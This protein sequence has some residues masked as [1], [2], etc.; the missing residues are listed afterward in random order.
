MRGSSP[1]C[2]WVWPSWVPVRRPTEIVVSITIVP[3]ARG[4]ATSPA[5]RARLASTTPISAPETK[6]VMASPNDRR[7]LPDYYFVLG[8]PPDATETELHAAWPRQPSGRA[9]AREVDQLG[10]RRTD[11]RHQAR[12]IRPTAGS[13]WLAPLR[14]GPVISPPGPMDDRKPRGP[15]ARAEGIRPARFRRTLGGDDEP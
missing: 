6:E 10:A 12:G 5:R 9:R 11:Q 1:D 14:V 3:L 4:L 15:A 2:C 13:R 8:V 7:P